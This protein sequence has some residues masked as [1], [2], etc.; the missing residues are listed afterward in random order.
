M[1][2]AAMNYMLI[3]GAQSEAP[4]WEPGHWQHPEPE[5]Q[6]SQ[7]KLNQPRSSFPEKSQSL[8]DVP[9]K[10]YYFMCSEA[11]KGG[12]RGRGGGV[13]FYWKWKWREGLFEE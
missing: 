2:E 1:L 9:D 6:N 13:G 7:H 5:N 12:L 3:S 8:A 11:G 4:G 10:F